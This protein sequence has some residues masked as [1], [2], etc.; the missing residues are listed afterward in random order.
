MNLG[1]ACQPRIST[2][3]AAFPSSINTGAALQPR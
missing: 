3:V 1:P 2:G